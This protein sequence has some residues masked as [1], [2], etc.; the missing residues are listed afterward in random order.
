MLVDVVIQ[1]KP[2]VETQRDELIINLAGY[3]TELTSIEIKILKNLS[4]SS[5]DTILDDTDLI[6]TLEDSK[7]KAKLIKE[8]I[9]QAVEI[10]EM[11]NTTRNSY[12]SIALRGSILYFVIAD[13]AGID[14]MYQYSLKY[15]KNL[16]VDSIINSE[17][18]EDL[19]IRL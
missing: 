12:T 9:E 16:F 4:D 13:L 10:E 2:E 1:E 11:I 18:N 8:K 14:P 6:E 15:V 17:K 7:V 19:E 5:E 3:K